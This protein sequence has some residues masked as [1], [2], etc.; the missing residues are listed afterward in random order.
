VFV[1]EK[2][3][4]REEEEEERDTEREKERETAFVQPPRAGETNV[5]LDQNA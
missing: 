5:R 1:C 2:E 3:K 4:E